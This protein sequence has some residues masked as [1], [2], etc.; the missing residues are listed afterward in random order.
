MKTIRNGRN[1]GARHWVSTLSLV[2]VLAL[3]IS[4]SQTANSA[5]APVFTTLEPG[6][7]R[8]IGQEIPI[9]IVLVGYEPGA[10]AREIDTAALLAQLPEIYRPIAR[11]PAF[12]G[13]SQ[14]LGLNYSYAYNVVFADSGFEDDFFGYLSSIA[15][16]QPLTLFQ[17]L[18][19]EQVNKT[20]EIASNA[21]ID[22]PSVEKWLAQNAGA[23][24]GIDTRQ[25]T[26]FLVNWYGRADFRPHVY[27]KIGE[28]DPD[29]QFDFGLL[30]SRKLIAWGGTTP[31]DEESGLGTLARI[32]FYDLS[33]GPE[34][35]SGNWNVDDADLDGDGSLDYRM[36]PVWEYGSAAGYRP[37]NDLSGDLGKVVRF[38][39]IN[40]LFTTSP[41]FNPALSAPKL[42]ST[43]KLNL[44]L[45]QG[46]PN[47]DGRDWINAP[48]AL[49]EISKL[50]PLTVFSASLKELKFEGRPSNV[51]DCAMTFFT[52]DWQSCF[53]NRIGVPAADLFLYHTDKL[54][55]FVDGGADYEIPTF[56]YNL[57]DNRFVPFL[58]YADDNWADGAQSY[59]YCLD[60]PAIRDFGYGFTATIIHEAGHHLGISHPHDG[61]DSELGFDYFPS[62][63]LYFT[64]SGDQCNS[65]MSYIDLNWDFSQFDRDNMA[66]YLTAT[67]LNM[68]NAI[69]PKII[70]S[71]RVDRAASHLT[72]ADTQAGQALTE[73][74]ASEWAAAA[75]RA[76]ACY[77]HVLAAADMAAV[78]IEPQAHPADY[79]ARG[80]GNSYMFIDPITYNRSLP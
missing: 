78:K 24:L 46:D 44:H 9:N 1:L 32:W 60:S 76:K 77:D 58:G 41:L 3:L 15:Q 7:T 39:A 50:Q 79:K 13:V 25:Y 48:Y 66:R 8:V 2:G 21:W 71:P 37:F 14:P 65:M 61:Y 40:L 23:K 45:Y 6:K 72:T 43:V 26:V 56:C 70:K 64:H 73:F 12:Y 18:Y 42:P 74:A 68:A 31:D 67:Y 80:K 17:E 11:V 36:P 75:A 22:A 27:T 62:G 55:Q 34:A 4:A 19:N 57:D 54:I 47:A 28:P 33:A 10:G 51:Y 30:E 20:E 49:T 52:P 35:W 63:D 53:G 5:G 38:V 69:L 29:T 59:L 16:D